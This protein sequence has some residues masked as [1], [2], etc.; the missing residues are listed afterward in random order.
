MIKKGKKDES[1]LKGFSDR[2]ISTNQ[3]EE[4]S[5][6]QIQHPCVYHHP[7]IKPAKTSEQKFHM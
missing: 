5:Q 3:K 4:Y 7:C 6:T 2:E 1:N